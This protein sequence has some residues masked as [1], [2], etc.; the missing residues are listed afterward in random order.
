MK[1]HEEQKIQKDFILIFTDVTANL[2]HED[3]F[4]HSDDLTIF[5]QC[6]ASIPDSVRYLSFVPCL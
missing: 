2:V 1:G 3:P 5:R 6:A 4:R